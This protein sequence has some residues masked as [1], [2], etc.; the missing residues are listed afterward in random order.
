VNW[1]QTIKF[2]HCLP[3]IALVSFIHIRLLYQLSKRNQTW[4]Q[5]YN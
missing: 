5:R 4:T 3:D 1:G 2:P